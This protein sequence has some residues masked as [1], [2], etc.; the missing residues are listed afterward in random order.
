MAY[1]NA[2]AHNLAAIRACRREAAPVRAARI[3]ELK[4]RNRKLA[5]QHE[6]DAA[7]LV[8]ARIYS[9]PTAKRVQEDW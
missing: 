4:E 6:P 3:A 9:M 8:A 7:D 2:V 1:T 5:E